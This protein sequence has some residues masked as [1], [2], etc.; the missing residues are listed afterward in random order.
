MKKPKKLEQPEPATDRAMSQ[1]EAADA[2]AMLAATIKNDYDFIRVLRE[3]DPA[4]REQVYKEIAPF[5]G[6]DDPRPYH[7]MSFDVDA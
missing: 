6:Y 4:L 2:M 3:A 7:L 1:G 5:V